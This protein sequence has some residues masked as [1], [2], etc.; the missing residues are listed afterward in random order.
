MKA[1]N[2]L[3]LALLVGCTPVDSGEPPSELPP[4]TERNTPAIA[5]PMPDEHLTYCEQL[6]RDIG[7]PVCKGS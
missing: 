6:A 2:A 4:L 1:L 7:H 3:A 5:G